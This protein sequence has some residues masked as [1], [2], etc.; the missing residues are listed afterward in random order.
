MA[1]SVISVLAA[2]VGKT[3]QTK[4]KLIPAPQERT[5]VVR[6]MERKDQWSIT[7]KAVYLQRNANPLNWIPSVTFGT[8][9]WFAVKVIYVMVTTHNTIGQ[10]SDGHPQWTRFSCL[11]TPHASRSRLLWDL[12]TVIK[13]LN[14]AGN[15]ISFLRESKSEI[16]LLVMKRSCMDLQLGKPGGCLRFW[17]HVIVLM[18]LCKLL[19]LINVFLL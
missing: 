14:F 17:L 1:W 7:W 10:R 6:S 11:F 18:Q 2:E 9:K 19:R 15:N 13:S 4:Q 12:I 16:L 8:V 3:V 5:A